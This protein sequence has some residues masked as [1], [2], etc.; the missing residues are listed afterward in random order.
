MNPIFLNS[1]LF[2]TIFTKKSM[3]KS[4][5][6]L[7][8]NVYIL[9]PLEGNV[10][11]LRRQFERG[12]KILKFVSPRLWGVHALRNALGKKGATLPKKLSTQFAN[13][14]TN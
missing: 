14:T 5:F 2:C 3:R 1:I 13:E 12:T 7:N 8:T 9:G 6:V 4:T 11:K 10:R